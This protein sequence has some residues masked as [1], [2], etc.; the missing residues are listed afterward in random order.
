[1]L[2]TLRALFAIGILNIGISWNSFVRRD[3]H[4]KTFTGRRP[5]EG[6]EEE[7]KIFPRRESLK[8]TKR[9]QLVEPYCK[10]S[11]ILK[12]QLRP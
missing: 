11:K 7:R 6:T 3:I 1:M 10:L 9:R 12:S 2:K 5:L 4:W 8:G